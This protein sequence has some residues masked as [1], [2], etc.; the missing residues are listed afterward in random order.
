MW[1]HFVLC[2]LS[3]EQLQRYCKCLSRLLFIFAIKHMIVSFNK[4]NYH[5]F[6]MINNL[7]FVFSFTI[8]TQVHFII[9]CGVISL[10][11]FENTI[12]LK[13]R[14]ETIMICLS[15]FFITSNEFPTFASFIHWWYMNTN[16]SRTCS[17]WLNLKNSK[18]GLPIIC[19]A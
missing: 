13:L 18:I 10:L 19:K 17:S 5:W 2:I 9:W 6:N 4:I 8:L 16:R 7:I 12:Q 14:L 1:I 15:H 3:M 11:K